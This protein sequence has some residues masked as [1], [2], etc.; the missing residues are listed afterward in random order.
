MWSNPS[1]AQDHT[2]GWK[3]A[4]LHEFPRRIAFDRTEIS[5]TVDTR[6]AHRPRLRHMHERRINHRLA[7]RMIVTARVTTNLCAFTMLPIREEREI[8]HC[9]EDA[10]LRWLESVARIRQCPG[11]DHRH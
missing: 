6:F 4:P 7:V 5:L 9:I 1:V 2:A 11:N 3:L 10:S 8:M